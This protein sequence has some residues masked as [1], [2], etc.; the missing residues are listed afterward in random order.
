MSRSN[1]GL[2]IASFF[3]SQQR[4]KFFPFYP[5]THNNLMELPNA[6]GYINVAEVRVVQ[7]YYFVLQIITLV[8]LLLCI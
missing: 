2:E 8:S 5:G 7:M 4:V 6:T 1:V 3:L